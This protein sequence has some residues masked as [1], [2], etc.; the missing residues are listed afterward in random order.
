[1]NRRRVLLILSIT[2]VCACDSKRYTDAPGTSPLAVH[3]AAAHQR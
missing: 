2:L 3:L 1:M